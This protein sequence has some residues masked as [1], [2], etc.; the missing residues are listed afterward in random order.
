MEDTGEKIA[1]RCLHNR[2]QE[3]VC[4]SNDH[5]TTLRRC[6]ECGKLLTAEDTAPPNQ[7]AK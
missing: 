1:E 2:L 4:N 6:C 3:R 7:Q 5:E